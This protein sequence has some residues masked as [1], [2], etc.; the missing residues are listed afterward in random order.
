MFLVDSLKSGPTK[1]ESKMLWL[2]PLARILPIIFIQSKDFSF[3]SAPSITGHPPRWMMSSM[4]GLAWYDSISPVEARHGFRGEEECNKEKGGGR[5]EGDTWGGKCTGDREGKVQHP[6]AWPI[7]WSSLM[8][9]FH[10]LQVCQVLFVLQQGGAGDH[11]GEKKT[12]QDTRINCNKSYSLWFIHW[13][14]INL[15]ILLNGGSWCFGSRSIK[16]ESE[17]WCKR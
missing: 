10:C 15:I 3:H 14:Y 4:R 1:T 2:N 7:E 11:L 8:H 6:T 13:R 12:S 9:A 5:R 16:A 17:R